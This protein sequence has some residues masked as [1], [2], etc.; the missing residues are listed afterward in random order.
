MDKYKI[1][2]SKKATSMLVSHAAFL[3][4]VSTESAE[5]LIAE[6]NKTANSLASM[7]YRNP[8]LIADYIPK[9][10]YRTITFQKRYLIIYQVIDDTVYIDYVLDCRQ[11]YS[12]LLK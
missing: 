2:V 3:A 7:P 10:Q 5:Q 11:D 1:V 4:K 6:F 12:W 9:H 8:W